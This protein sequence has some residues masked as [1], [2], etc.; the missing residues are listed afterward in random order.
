D[1]EWI[2]YNSLNGQLVMSTLSYNQN[3]AKTTCSDRGPYRLVELRSALIKKAVYD[4]LDEQGVSAAWTGGKT[5]NVLF[6]DYVWSSD[7][8]PI[9][10]PDWKNG[11][12]LFP[13][14]QIWYESS[15]TVVQPPRKLD[16]Q[17]KNR[18]FRALCQSI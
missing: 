11:A 16:L 5:G 10:Y 18:L 15:I 1:K 17:H 6:K 12:I 2:L 4:F 14:P 3:D 7:E 9:S 8:S 13:L